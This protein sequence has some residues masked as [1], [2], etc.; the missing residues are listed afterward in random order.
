MRR[1]WGSSTRAWTCAS[2]SE[3]RL[4]PPRKSLAQRALI[5]RAAWPL[6]LLACAAPMAWL[7]AAAVADRLGPNP[8]EALVRGTGD[9][10]L[11]MLWLTLAVT[12]LRHATGWH[13]L[14]RFRRL[15]GLS[16][17][18]H[19]LAHFL[20]FAWLDMGLD[21]ASIARDLVRR[22]F[23]LAGA[24]ALLLMLPLAAT[25]FNT[26]IRR[27]GAVRW[28][29]LHRSVYAI[30]LLALLHFLWMRAAKNDQAEVAVYAL[31][32]AGL[33]GARLWRRRRAGAQA[34]PTGR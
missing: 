25:S 33:L 4:S 14:A 7:L 27:L 28:Q 3:P 10:T 30:A 11:R 2:S 23:I 9:W 5:H 15:L 20:C 13:A 34:R 17:F 32:L 18:V 24:L 6:A 26:A 31:V 29:A 16:A 8:A 22:P 12:P 21:A 19:A 1:R